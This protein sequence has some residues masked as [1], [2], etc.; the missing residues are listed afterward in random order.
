MKNNDLRYRKANPVAIS[1]IMASVVKKLN[2]ED[3]FFFENLKSKWEYIVGSTNAV[4]M[5]PASFRDGILTVVVSSPVWLTELR[6]RKKEII[7]KVNN[8][9]FVHKVTVRDIKFKLDKLQR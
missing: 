9:R 4:N 8:F 2:G 7:S 1:G 6:F 3:N 5:E